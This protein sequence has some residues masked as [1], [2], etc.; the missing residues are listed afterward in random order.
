MKKYVVFATLITLIVSANYFSDSIIEDA[1]WKSYNLPYEINDFSFTSFNNGFGVGNQSHALAINYVDAEP[2]FEDQ[3]ILAGTL[4]SKYVDR[5]M[6]AIAMIGYDAYVFGDY[7]EYGVIKRLYNNGKPSG[8]A[9]DIPERDQVKFDNFKFGD[10]S[11]F[12]TG[13][14]SGI[15][16]AV[17][18]NGTIAK[19]IIGEESTFVRCLDEFG[20][21]F[22]DENLNAV[23]ILNSNLFWTVGN[24]GTLLTSTDGGK[25]WLKIAL[26][27][28]ENLNSI[29]FS[30]QSTGFISG[31][32]GVLLKTEDSGKTWL[33]LKLKTHLDL[34]NIYFI[35]VD[36]GFVAADGG[37]I[38]ATY[39]SG[40]NWNVSYE[41]HSGNY[42]KIIMNSNNEL[43]VL[44][45]SNEFLVSKMF[46]NNLEIS[47]YKDVY[48]TNPALNEIVDLTE[49][50]IFEGYNGNFYPTKGYTRAEAIA[51]LSK[52]SKLTSAPETVFNDVKS[53]DWFFA[54]V[55]D[56]GGHNIINGYED[57]S[58][59]PNKIVTIEEICSILKN[60]DE[61]KGANTQ[62]IQATGRLENY[63]YKANISGWAL[64]SFNYC[65]EKKYLDNL[66]LENIK[67]DLELKRREAAVIIYNYFN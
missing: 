4:S 51:V 21:N 35:D 3:S 22:T 13:N 2:S 48:E 38:Y 26:S 34:S 67:P 16:V 39:D 37:N 59:R 41:N 64:E 43:W 61:V 50:G 58:F 20:N 66:D 19:L 65:L 29:W 28:T 42:N 25:N 54:Y 5:D 47:G 44:K 32:A 9:F 53:S 31:N 27:T 1:S 62:V 46:T 7:F 40:N 63:I 11:S 14:S 55:Q 30:N 8:Y 56:F 15:V 6:N 33:K 23:Q 45:D 60:L 17:G 52:I 49:N 36:N 10:A 12:S 18:S 57:G 24:N